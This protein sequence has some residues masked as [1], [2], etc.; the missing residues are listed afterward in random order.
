MLREQTYS[1]QT[2]DKPEFLLLEGFHYIKEYNT[3]ISIPIVH[4]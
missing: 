4:K 2:Q 1:V 3:R